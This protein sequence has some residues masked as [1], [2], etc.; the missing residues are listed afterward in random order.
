M[1]MNRSSIA[2]LAKSADRPFWSV[3][4]PTYNPIPQYLEQ[5]LNS[6]L[7]QHPGRNEMQIELIDDCSSSF[8][9][10]GLLKKVRDDRVSCY[11]QKHHVGIGRNW[12]ACIENAR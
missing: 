2:P 8:D 4:I 1:H 3:M 11:R 5:S 9:P 10:E 12:N 6:V 7:E